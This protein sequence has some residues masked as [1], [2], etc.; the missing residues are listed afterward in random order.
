MTMVTNCRN[1]LIFLEEE[2]NEKGM[3]M[4]IVVYPFISPAK[5]NTKGMTY[6][7]LGGT[8]SIVTNM[9][10]LWW[11]FSASCPFKVHE[12]KKRKQNQETIMFF[13]L[14]LLLFSWKWKIIIMLVLHSVFIESLFYVIDQFCFVEVTLK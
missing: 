13:L 11:H 7:Q 3:K 6:S 12:Q 2:E 5:K 14:L 9:N 10:K 1:S 8:W 4:K